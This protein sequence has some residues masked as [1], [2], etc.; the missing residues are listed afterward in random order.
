MNI[1][2]AAQA[3]G[4]S[5]KMIRHYESV[6][7]FPHAERTEAG[8]RQ[9]GE[10]E[11]NTLRFIR[12]SRDLGFS[13]EQIRALLGLWQ[14]R[15]RPS[16]QVKALAQAHLQELE[17]KL[18]ELQAMKATLQDLVHGCHGDDRPD[19]PILDTLAQPAMPRAGVEPAA[20][21]NLRAK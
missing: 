17:Q 13:I 8:Y 9:Y 21:A 16:R 19:C 6:G 18:H 14:D 4:V 20:R 11:L 2:Q 1:G 10:R 15:R 12:H 3:S 7:L 5:A